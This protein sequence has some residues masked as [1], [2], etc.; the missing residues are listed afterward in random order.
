MR[1]VVSG[2]YRG[3]LRAMVHDIVILRRR[4]DI[5][6]AVPQMRAPVFLASIDEAVHWRGEM[7]FTLARWHG[8]KHCGHQF[9]HG[10]DRPYD[11]KLFD[12]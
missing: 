10:N 2:D 9:P 8:R 5:C 12:K 4:A 7:Q 11:R 1:A 3:P 6:H